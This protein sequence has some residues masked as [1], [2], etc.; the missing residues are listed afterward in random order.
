[1][2]SPRFDY[3]RPDSL[4]QVLALMA[5]HGDEAQMIAGGQSLVPIM[6]MRLASPS[7]LVDLNHVPDLAGI[8]LR[9]KWLRIGALTR[10]AEMAR[11]PEVARHARCWPARRLTSP[12]RRSA[13]AARSAAASPPPTRLGM[14]RLLPDPGRAHSPGQP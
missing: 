12:T 13:T 3:V 14:A 4:D 7:V 8:E 5:E 10:H 2:K 9:G 1:M 11:S 6:N